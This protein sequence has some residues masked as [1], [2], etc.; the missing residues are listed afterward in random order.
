MPSTKISKYFSSHEVGKSQTAERLGIENKPPRWVMDN[1]SELAVHVLD[2]I[3]HEFGRP[4][5]PQSWYRGEDLEKALTW[6]KGFRLWCAKHN[7]PWLSRKS[8]SLD[9]PLKEMMGVQQAWEEYYERKSH[10]KGQA[11]DIEIPGVDNDK[12]FFWIREH[13][14]FDQLIRE[15]P[16]PSDPMSGWVH[17]SWAGAQVNRQ[18][19]FSIPYYDRYA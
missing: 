7:K 11:A 17:V 2:P 19:Y 18:S 8:L 9:H 12:L 10:P 13:L 15:F 5:S 16:K 1:A 6:E 3:R 14:G 4:F